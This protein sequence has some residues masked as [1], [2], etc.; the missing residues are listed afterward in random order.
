VLLLEGVRRNE[1]M[2]FDQSG[3]IVAIAERSPCACRALSHKPLFMIRPG[4]CPAGDARVPDF[5]GENV[6][7]LISES[8][9]RTRQINEL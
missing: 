8:M 2:A 6:S 3:E 7:Q 4:R 5:A 1:L 9:Y